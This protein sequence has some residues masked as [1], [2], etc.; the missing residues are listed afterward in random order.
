M[1]D[2]KI[3]NSSIEPKLAAGVGTFKVKVSFQGAVLGWWT[4]NGSPEYWIT[5]V[6]E[7]NASPF[8]YV[9]SGQT[10]W[11]TGSNNYLS[12]RTNNPSAEG[13]KMRGWSYAAAWK[14]Q[15]K[16]LLCVTNGKL[17]GTKENYFYANGE[18]VVDVDLVQS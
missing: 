8:Y 1:D 6:D 18:N 14:L 16:N 11:A 13:I 7:A 5:V 9:V 2:D 12:Y 15:G 3:V 17:V 4:N 10:Y